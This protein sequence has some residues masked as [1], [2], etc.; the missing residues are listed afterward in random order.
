M[1]IIH[2]ETKAVIPAEEYRE[3]KT[4]VERLRRE[5]AELR[6]RLRQAGLSPVTE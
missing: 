4:E 3:L 2:T 1:D 6:E 5:N